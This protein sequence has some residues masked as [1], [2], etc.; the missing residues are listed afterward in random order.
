MQ[1][2]DVGV[3]L[4]DGATQ[5]LEVAAVSPYAEARAEARERIGRFIEVHVDCSLDELV[6]RD[7]KGLYRRALA[8]E[9]TNFTGVSDPYEPPTAPDVRVDSAL[10]TIEES[11]A[12]ILECLE[13]RGYLEPVEARAVPAGGATTS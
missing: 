4:G 8:G 7:V 5:P 2:A 13:A 10:Q 1:R 9:I 12:A 6:R 3:D 11:L